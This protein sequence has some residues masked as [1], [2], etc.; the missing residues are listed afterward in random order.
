[1]PSSATNAATAPALVNEFDSDSASRDAIMRGT[2][3]S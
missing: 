1:M 2:R 3:D